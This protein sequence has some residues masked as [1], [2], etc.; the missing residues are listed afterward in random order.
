MLREIMEDK[1][2][3]IFDLISRG[4]LASLLSDEITEPWYGQ[5]MTGPQTMAYMIQLNH[6]MEK[7][8]VKVD[9]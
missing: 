1:D 3:P 6:W 7:Y 2:A 5:L 9:V 8:R 4:A